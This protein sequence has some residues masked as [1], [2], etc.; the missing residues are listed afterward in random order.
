MALKCERE[1]KEIVV[2]DCVCVRACV[3]STHTLLL[4]QTEVKVL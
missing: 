1:M 4:L 3:F 2:W